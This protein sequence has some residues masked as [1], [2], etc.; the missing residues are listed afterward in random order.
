MVA[1]VVPDAEAISGEWGGKPLA[2][3]CE[4]PKF[5]EAVEKDMDRVADRN[6]L[7]GFEKVRSIRLTAEPFTP[8][9]G[10]LTPTMK[11]RRS[12]AKDHFCSLIDEMYSDSE[13]AGVS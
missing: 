1:I 11:L 9:N 8:E 13:T 6:K 2:L 10:L 5:R 3:L 7:K 12:I 4:N